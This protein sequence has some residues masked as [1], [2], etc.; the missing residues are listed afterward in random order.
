[1]SNCRNAP[2]AGCS[3]RSSAVTQRVTHLHEV[4]CISHVQQAYDSV[5]VLLKKDTDHDKLPFSVSV[6]ENPRPIGA[7]DK[8]L[9]VLQRLGDVGEEGR[10]LSRLAADLGLNKASLH[11][12]L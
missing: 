3:S 10:A 5:E 2:C 12:T 7:V 11:H 1:M 9:L 4:P 6:M 8:A